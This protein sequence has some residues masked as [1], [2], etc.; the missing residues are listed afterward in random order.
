MGYLKLNGQKMKSKAYWWMVAVIL[1]SAFLCR[2]NCIWAA[3]QPF[4]LDT[5]KD[6]VLAA[7]DFSNWQ[8]NWVVET[9]QPSRISY[10]EEDSLLDVVAEKGLTLWYKYPFSGNLSITYEACAVQQG[11]PFD[12][13]ID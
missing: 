7:D 10:R 6:R 11:G 8:A 2:D 13:V 4:R 1:V 9:E 5:S 3:N 12:R